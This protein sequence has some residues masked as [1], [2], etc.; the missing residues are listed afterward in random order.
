MTSEIR[1]PTIIIPYPGASMESGVQD[2]AIY[3]RPEANGVRVESTILGVIHKNEAYKKALQIVYLAN[4]PGDFMVKNH[5]VEE[6]YAVNIHFAREGKA[7]FTENMIHHFERFFHESFES[8]A[9]LGSFDSLEILGM[10]EEELFRVWVP[11]QDFA[12]INGQSVKKFHDRY[13]VNYDIPAL[14]QKNSGETDVFSMILRSFLPYEQFHG[15]I[16]SING[17]LKEEGIITNPVLYSHVFHY[18]KGPFEQ[19]LDGKGYIYK[20]GDQHIDLSELSFFS[21]LISND[22]EREEIL[23][24]ISHPIMQFA[25]DGGS[26]EEHNLFVYTYND[27][28]EEA[29]LK[30]KSKI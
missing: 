8:A 19:I 9:V 1:L 4:L 13:I 28:Y 12:R 21:Y 22:C 5:I 11:D 2:I 20:E 23:D 15:L 25:V 30:F 18:S 14:L 29:L 27:T 17:A 3:L 16:N 6:H 26:T 24:S 7:A 10:T